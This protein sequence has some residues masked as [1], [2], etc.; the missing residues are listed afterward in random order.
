MPGTGRVAFTLR[1]RWGERQLLLRLGPHQLVLEVGTDLSLWRTLNALLGERLPWYSRVDADRD[2]IELTLFGL[3]DAV[4]TRGATI[5]RADKDS[6]SQL[7]VRRFLHLDPWSDETYGLVRFDIEAGHH[8]LVGSDLEADMRLED[9]VLVDSAASHRDHFPPSRW[10]VVA[11]LDPDGDPD[12][13]WAAD[14]LAR[15][16]QNAG[17]L[18]QFLDAWGTYSSREEELLHELRDSVDPVRYGK[19]RMVEGDRQGDRHQLVIIGLNPNEPGAGIFLQAL[20]QREAAG[21]QLAIEL[22]E[23]DPQIHEMQ[24]AVV[25]HVRLVDPASGDIHLSMSTDETVAPDGWC[26]ISIR[27]DLTQINRRTKAMSELLDDRAGIPSLRSLLAGQTRIPPRRP[28]QRGTPPG[29]LTVDLTDRQR[30]AVQIALATPDIAM[31][32]GPPGTGKTKVIAAIENALGEMD[33]PDRTNRLILLTST[34]NDA[35]D[36]VAARTRVFGLPPNRVGTR[37]NIDPIADW[38]RERLA[39]SIEVLEA[40]PEHRRH[41]TLAERHAHLQGSA[42]THDQLVSAL[43]ELAMLGIDEEIEQLA[44]STATELR[45]RRMKRSHRDRLDARIRALRTSTASWSDDG[46]ERV[47]DLLRTIDQFGLATTWREAFEMRL[48]Q[49]ADEADPWIAARTL[50]DDMLDQLAAE[51][52]DRPRAVPSD[53]LDIFVTA[54]SVA[55]RHLKRT[56]DHPLTVEQALEAYV[57]DIEQHPDEA[58]DAIRQYTVVHAAT[59]QGASAFARL[60]DGTRSAA[61][62]EN[63]IVDEAARVSPL[64]LLIPLVQ[65]RQRVVLV[66]DHRQLPAVYDEGIARGLPQGDLLAECLF[67][68]LFN[69]LKEQDVAT[70]VQRTIT[71][72]RQFRMHPRLGSF[73]SRV[74]YEPH[75]ER[76][77]NGATED[78]LGHDLGRFEN[79]TSVWIDVPVE[80]GRARRSSRRSWSRAAEAEVVASLVSEIVHEHPELSVGVITFYSDQ[81]DLVL[82]LLADDL[83]ERSRG[84]AT[85]VRPEYATLMRDGIH[86]EERLR[87]GTVDAFQGKEFDVV[88]LSMVRSDAARPDRTPRAVFGFLTVE[89]RFCVALSRQKR[90][91]LVVGDRGMVDHPQASAIVGL[92]ELRD[93]CDQEQ[94]ASAG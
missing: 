14:A 55:K 47:A 70:G 89:N 53:V 19:V 54:I 61:T 33:G 74:F 46:P 44:R 10:L 5:A 72:D 34:Q 93:L 64:D 21:I 38:R 30:R 92:R 68:R 27:G 71:L 91:L 7:S 29:T 63:A 75:G 1:D 87:I 50:K 9:R 32:Q 4:P 94:V 22:T 40:N 59:C 37:A 51:V 26:A 15:I 60:A 80:E 65:A 42:V 69:H 48:R 16:G 12:A 52:D 76:I 36:Q 28:T 81:R 35:V 24:P 86:P 6:T 77:E 13:P 25:G 66:G 11:G 90:L 41:R 18:G 39:A 23:D 56:G 85:T 17:G 82:E 49:L 45:S 79:R 62:F 83:T 67:E 84:G 73:V 88:I 8:K 2:H 20:A 78:S 31:I 57:E 3:S 43:D 58:D